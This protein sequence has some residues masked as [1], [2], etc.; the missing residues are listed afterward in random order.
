[1]PEPNRPTSSGFLNLLTH[2]RPGL[3]GPV[4]CRIRPWGFPFEAL[5]L[6]RSRTPSPTPFPSCRLCCP[7]HT[8]RT[9]CQCDRGRTA[10]G[11]KTFRTQRSSK[12]FGSS[13]RLQG[14]APRE[15][16]PPEPSCLDS[17]RARG[18]LGFH[19]LQGVLPRCDGTTFAV[20]PLMWLLCPIQGTEPSS[21]SG[22]PSQQDWLVS[23]ET[24]DPPGVPSLLAG[25][26]RSKS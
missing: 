26:S 9:R 3:T 8:Y 7:L 15:S 20:P 6:P 13:P 2:H 24:A 10:S 11:P 12:R 4:S 21:T 23:L 17:K 25:H 14:L 22:S 1:L 16:P 19:P 18:S 5:F